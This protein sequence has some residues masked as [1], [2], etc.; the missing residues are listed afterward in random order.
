[1]PQAW[2]GMLPE[3]DGV[4]HAAATFDDDEEASDRG[5]LDGL[6]P[7]LTAAE[8]SARFVYTGGC[9]LYGKYNGAVATENAPFDPLPTF[10]WC[11]RHIQRVF[12]APGIL[13][14]V[15]H[16]A[17][18]YEPDGGVFARFLQDSVKRDAVRVVGGESVRW[19]L[20][21]SEDLAILYRLV[22]ESS[23]S[24]ETYLGAAIDGLPV[25][26]IARAFARRFGTPP[27]EPEVISADNVAAELGEWARGFALDQMQSGDKAK[28]QLGWEPKHL[29]PEAEIAAI[30]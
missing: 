15:I 12:D 11:V 25:G 8:R 20:V 21:H 17:M 14:N 30:G 4:I 23:S 24:G 19:P 7:F 2:L 1:M 22:L 29:D 18:V 5:L 6:L 27:T 13:P 28:T 16:P 10:A 3:L 26:R 9:W